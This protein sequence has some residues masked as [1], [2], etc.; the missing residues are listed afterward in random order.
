MI[1]IPILGYFA[2][3][4]LKSAK[5]NLLMVNIDVTSHVKISPSHVNLENVPLQQYPVRR[6]HA[7]ALTVSVQ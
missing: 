2:R 3:V 1:T 4:F 5:F 6:E 7:S